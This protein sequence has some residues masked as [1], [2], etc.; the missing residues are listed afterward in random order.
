MAVAAV[1][2]P[3]CSLGSHW[4]QHVVGQARGAGYGGSAVAVRS[5]DRGGDRQAGQDLPFG[6]VDAAGAL[7]AHP[8]VGGEG[9]DGCAVCAADAGLRAVDGA[10]RAC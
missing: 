10:G 7:S 1:A 2:G 6:I 8:G 4:P 9:A 5:L 3:R